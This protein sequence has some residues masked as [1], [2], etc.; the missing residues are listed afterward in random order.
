MKTTKKI[1]STALTQESIE[2]LN[3]LSNH[4]QEN[5]SQIIRRAICLLYKTISLNKEILIS[6]NDSTFLTK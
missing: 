1:L 4:F 3:A 6:S 5:N 2:Q